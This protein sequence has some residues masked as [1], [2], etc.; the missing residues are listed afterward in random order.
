LID[1]IIAA[2]PPHFAF[3]LIFS[4]EA[5]FAIR[6]YE[7]IYAITRRPKL[8]MMSFAMLLP[9]VCHA[10]APYGRLMREAS[11]LSTMICFAARLAIRAVARAQDA[12][13]RATR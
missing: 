9:R 12:S 1:I 6:C 10:S 4:Y 3:S 13:R 11:T 8:D 2:T 7:D 5:L